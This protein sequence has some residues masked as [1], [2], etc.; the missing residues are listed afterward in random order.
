[1]NLS[2]PAWVYSNAEF[3]A[4]E[5]DTI[6]RHTPQLVCHENDIPDLGDYETFSFL[7]RDIFVI[8]SE[9][10]CIRAFYN[11]CRHRSHRLLGEERGNCGNRIV[12]PYHAWSYDST[13]ELVNV[14]YFEDYEGMSMADY[15][16][17]EMEHEIYQGL[18]F[19]L[20]GSDGRSVSDWLAPIAGELEHYRLPEVESITDRSCYTVRANWKN[21]ADN[22]IDALHVRVAH[23]GLNSLLNK[24]YGITA[25]AEDVYRL[26]GQVKEIV[27]KSDLAQRYH[28][29][30]P[31]VPHLPESHQKSWLYFLL[32]P[33]LMFN[34][35]PDQVEFMQFLPVDESHTV[36]RYGTYAV[37][38]DRPEMQEAR[39]LNI[40][41]NVKVGE[42]DM[43]LVTSVQRGMENE[44]FDQGPLGNNE[45]GLLGFANTLR[46]LLPVSNEST[47]PPA[48]MVSTVNDRESGQQADSR[49]IID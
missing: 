12:C 17:V 31:Y 35:Y 21:G 41:L 30:L 1:M 36:I 24:S 48:G 10:G 4:L 7:D 33:N 6:F 2:L 16:L 13:G 9:D 44:C 42:E 18:I 49:I 5:R 25:A 37:P 19:V 29:C 26:E 47:A 27:G 38:D 46:Q 3:F 23:P 15:G 43:S 11:V 32:W 40:D 39:Q 22:Y 14:P 8:R 20:F 34:L 45:I 28:E